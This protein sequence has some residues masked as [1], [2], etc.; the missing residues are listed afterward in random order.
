MLHTRQR[1]PELETL[2]KLGDYGMIYCKKLKATEK[3]NFKKETRISR[4]VTIINISEI[5]MTVEATSK[6]VI[7]SRNDNSEILSINPQYVFI[8]TDKTDKTIKRTE[9]DVKINIYIY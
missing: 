1:L 2:V 8:T 3:F 9:L 7:K 4:F 6:A 5:T